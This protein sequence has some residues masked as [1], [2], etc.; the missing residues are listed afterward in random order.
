MMS[1]IL[2]ILVFTFQFKYDPNLNE[3]IEKATQNVN[4]NVFYTL[5]FAAYTV[6]VLIIIGVI[7]LFY[8]L[9]YGILLKRL[10]RN[11]KEL[12]KLDL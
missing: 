5:L 4:P 8:K 12:E 7:W 2:F 11:Y 1:F 9:L 10:N 3:V 6:C